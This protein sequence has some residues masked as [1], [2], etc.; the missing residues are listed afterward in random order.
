MIL[1]PIG[2][3]IPAPWNILWFF[4][5][6]LQERLHTF[7]FILYLSFHSVPTTT[8]TR[9]ISFCT[10]NNWNWQIILI[11]RTCVFNHFFSFFLLLF[12]LFIFILIFFFFLF[13]FFLDSC[14]CF[15]RSSLY[16]FIQVWSLC[17]FLYIRACFVLFSLYMYAY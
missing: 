5:L 4:I 14:I 12:L 11:V 16:L 17:F 2:I 6:Y 1:L 7:H 15:S 13:I 9:S 8:E 3:L 10:Y